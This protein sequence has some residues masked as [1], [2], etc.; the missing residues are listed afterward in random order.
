MTANKAVCY[1]AHHKV[2]IVDA[3]PAPAPKSGEARL[4][5]I[6]S[7]VSRG[8]ERVVFSGRVPPEEAD[9]MRP[10]HMRGS[11]PFPV[12]Y[13]YAAV[14]RVEDGPAEW[15][16]RR[17]FA[18]HPHQL[19]YTIP[20]SDL[21]PLP[22]DLPSRRATLAANAETALNAVWDAGVGPGDRV[23]VVG[24]GLVGALIGALAARTPG[25]DVLF[26]DV[27]P[28]KA[29]V[30]DAFGARFATPA[31]APSDYGADVVFHVS[32]TADGLAT[33]V[34][35]AGDEGAVVEA[36]WYGAGTVAATLGGAFHR[37]RLRL[38]STQVGRVSP[39]RRARW[40]HGRRLAKAVELLQ[41]D[42]YDALVTETAAFDDAPTAV[43]RWLAPG[44][45]GLGAALIA[46]GSDA[47]R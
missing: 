43:P 14:G 6:C 25:V 7:G 3:P 36:S 21:T 29:G 8:T 42:R 44:S 46:P 22:D 20:L 18:L 41:D 30:A 17:A 47:G 40:S 24:L 34:D 13:G 5:L 38:I 1:A 4:R 28:V 33:A 37:G 19:A 9:A 35:L 15:V 2:E 45:G 31:D 10:P 12:V 11:F 39:R 27:D 26:V 32:A 16:G 23:A